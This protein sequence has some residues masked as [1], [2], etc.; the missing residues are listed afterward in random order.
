VRE[1]GAAEGLKQTVGRLGEYIAGWEGNKGLE[2][3]VVLSRFFKA[4]RALVFEAFTDPK[5][6]AQWWGPKDFTNPVCEIDLRPGGAILIHMHHPA[7]F[8]HPM[9]GTVKEIVKNERFVFM[10]TPLDDAGQVLAEVLTTVTFR[11]EAGGTRLTVEAHG[12]GLQ[13]IARMMFAG[14]QEG[15]S[16][17]LDKFEALVAKL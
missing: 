9:T 12:K 5:H 8:S 11:D 15:W 14:M 7:G 1:Y 3:R 10:A 17:S 4:P 16:Q 13:P 2:K 6:V